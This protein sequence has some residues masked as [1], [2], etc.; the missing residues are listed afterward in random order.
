M[1]RDSLKDLRFA[2]AGGSLGG[3]CAGVALSGLGANVDIYERNPGAMETRGAG[4]VVQQELTNLLQRHGAA[5]RDADCAW[6]C[7]WFWRD[8]GSIGP[9]VEQVRIFLLSR[10]LTVNWILG[11]ERA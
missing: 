4:I 11:G 3:L 7:W 1:P 9:T 6:R 5:P 10:G 2:V 8:L